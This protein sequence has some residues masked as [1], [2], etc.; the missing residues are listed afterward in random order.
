MTER[1]IDLWQEKLISAIPVV[2]LVAYVAVVL[3]LSLR[4]L[5][6]TDKR[7]HIPEVSHL[8]S[9]I[10]LRAHRATDKCA[11]TMANYLIVSSF[12]AMYVSPQTISCCP[13]DSDLLSLY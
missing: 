5:K 8:L 11:M 3:V 4:L 10:R 12:N 2:C 13:R 7:K 1:S 9:I 6:G